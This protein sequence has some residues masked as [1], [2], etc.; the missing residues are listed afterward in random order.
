MRNAQREAIT[1]LRGHFCYSIAR[2]CGKS[3]ICP[4][5]PY[6]MESTLNDSRDYYD[7]K[8]YCKRGGR[9]QDVIEF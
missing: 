2:L 5:D 6:I 3:F 9:K 7:K 1:Y 4:S 8:V